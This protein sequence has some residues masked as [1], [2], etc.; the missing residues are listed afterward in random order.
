V[1][2]FEQ[3]SSWFVVALFLVVIAVVA[4]R[5]PSP[6]TSDRWERLSAWAAQHAK[7][8]PEFDDDPI[9]VAEL[10]ETLRTEKLYADL[11]RL[12]HLVA[13]D[14][15]MS[16]TRQMGNRLAYE[17]LQ[18]QLAAERERPILLPAGG[19]GGLRPESCELIGS[20]RSG[21]ESLDVRWR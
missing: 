2:D 10:R 1:F 17:Q 14:T 20:N 11:A 9:E 3:F 19:G 12:R 18:Q 6:S 7:P 16:A 8:D 13:T 5:Q 21:P 15:Y 4:T